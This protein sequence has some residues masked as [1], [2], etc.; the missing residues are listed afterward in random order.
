MKTINLKNL[1]KISHNIHK[2]L[3]N[4]I[5]VFNYNNTSS[6]KVVKVSTDKW[7]S[8]QVVGVDREFITGAV[9]DSLIE[10]TK[11][12]MKVYS[13]IFYVIDVY[14]EYKDG[15]VYSKAAFSINIEFN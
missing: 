11:K 9:L 10:L 12:Y 14:K 15:Q 8:F 1:E 13:N 6:Y 5:S 7:F 2:K 4:L 3:D